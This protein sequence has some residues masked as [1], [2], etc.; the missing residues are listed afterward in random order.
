MSSPAR[1]ATARV[2]SRRG[3]ARYTRGRCSPRKRL[4]DEVGENLGADDESSERLSALPEPAGRRGDQDHLVAGVGRPVP[5]ELGAD[6]E[7]PGA[8]RRVRDTRRRL[9]GG[10]TAPPPDADTGPGPRAP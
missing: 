10:R 4:W 2:F 8:L 1:A 6:T 3:R 5:S 9:L 7:R